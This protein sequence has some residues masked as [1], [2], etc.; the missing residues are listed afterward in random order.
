MSESRVEIGP[1]TLY[2]GDC[3]KIIPTLSGIDAI[4]TDPPYGINF[5]TNHSVDGVRASWFGKTIHGDENLAAR[6]AIVR[7]A[8]D[9]PTLMFGSWK[10][11]KP[12][13]TRAVLIWDKGPQFGMGDLSLPWKPSWEEI[14]VIGKGFAG[15]RDEG[16]IK[17][18]SGVSWES[19]GRCHPNEKP[20]EL[21]KYLLRKTLGE[22][23]LDP[24]MGSGSTLE[25]CLRTGR[26]GVGIEKDPHY[27]AI[28]CERI[29]KA[30]AEEN[31]PLYATGE[32][33]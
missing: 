5:A 21:M 32:A 28:A 30:W 27:F 1:V 11:P 9:R 6:D 12:E 3:L 24:F 18:R 26:K 33:G 20:V 31:A 4:V 29:R 15:K 19:K 23:V 10:M 2:C 8:G 16:V 25:A 22:I 13:G 7:W 14:Y 17:G